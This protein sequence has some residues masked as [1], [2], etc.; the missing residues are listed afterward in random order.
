MHVCVDSIAAVKLHSVASV[1]LS[2]SEMNDRGKT[3][4]PYLIPSLAINHSVS[5]MP[6]TKASSVFAY[7]FCSNVTCFLWHL[8]LCI[9]P[10]SVKCF[11]VIQEAQIVHRSV[12]FQI[13]LSN[14]CLNIG[15]CCTVLLP[16]P[17]PLCSSP[18]QSLMLHSI[19]C[20]LL[21]GSIFLRNCCN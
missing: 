1:T 14:H 13:F 4:S 11:G 7:K 8:K 5:L 17:N 20:V 19:V 16:L 15:I 18:R 6:T 10:H 3:G 2:S 9:V 21:N 12:T